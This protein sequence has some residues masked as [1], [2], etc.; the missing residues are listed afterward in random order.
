MILKIGVVLIE[1]IRRVAHP[2]VMDVGVFVPP[3]HVK[4]YTDIRRSILCKTVKQ[5]GIVIRIGYDLTRGLCGA[6]TVFL[7]DHVVPTAF[8]Q[9]AY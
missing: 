1:R 4:D 6:C 3:R 7:N 5:M 2:T 9:R 8:F